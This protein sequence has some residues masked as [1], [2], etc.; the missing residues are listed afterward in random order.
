M[1]GNLVG[2]ENFNEI[3]S[4]IVLLTKNKYLKKF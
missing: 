4:N 2:F 3:I 1:K